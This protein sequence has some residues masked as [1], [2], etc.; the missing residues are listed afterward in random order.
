L[1]INV[2]KMSS[3]LFTDIK[4]ISVLLKEYGV[5]VDLS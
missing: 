4:I 1:K 2:S 5:T 3:L